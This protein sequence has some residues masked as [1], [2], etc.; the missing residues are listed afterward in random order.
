MELVAQTVMARAGSPGRVCAATNGRAYE[1][2]ARGRRRP[3]STAM[4]VARK[5]I[6]NRSGGW[7]HFI[8]PSLQKKMGRKMPKWYYTFKKAGCRMQT[9]GRGAQQQIYINA[10]RCNYHVAEGPAEFEVA[11]LPD[12]PIDDTS[13]VAL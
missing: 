13:V 1:A 6:N 3:S 9:V 4:A 10:N 8:N 11:D 12:A 5:Y 7:T 2:N